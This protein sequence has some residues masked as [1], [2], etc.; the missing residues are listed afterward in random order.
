MRVLRV[1]PALLLFLSCFVQAEDVVPLRFCF[2]DKQLL[3]HYAGKGTQVANPPGS[4]IEQLQAAV[5]N[6]PQLKLQLQRK[7]WL[8]CL[9][10]LEQNRIDAIVANFSVSRLHFSVYPMKPDN[11]PDYELALG[12]HGSCLVLRQDDS[13]GGRAIKDLV[14]ARPLGY[15]MPGYPEHATIL[16]VESQQKAFEL[17]LQGRVDATLTLCEASKVTLS[18]DLANG[19]QLVHPPLHQATGYLVYS[20]AFYQ[21]HANLASALWLELPKHRDASRYQRYLQPPQ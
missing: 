16:P 20:K 9:Q 19:L 1:L 11:T 17:V 5:K 13:L 7:P 8:R 15:L 21:N 6:I 18:H 3:P 12:Q 10:L 2:E 14:F 4:T